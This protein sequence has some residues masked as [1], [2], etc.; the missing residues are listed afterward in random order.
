[1]PLREDRCY[2]IAEAGSNHIGWGLAGCR[3]LIY[4]AAKSGADAC[5][6]Q[7]FKLEDILRKV[8]DNGRPGECGDRRTELNPEW[9]P[10][11]AD[12]CK[13]HNID[14]LCTPFAAWAVE[15]LNPYVEMWKVGS[16]EHKRADI[17]D[18]INLTKKPSIASY[19]RCRP[20]ANTT[21]MCNGCLSRINAT[22]HLYC[23]S[24]YPCLDEQLYVLDHHY[25]RYDGLSDH[26]TSTIIPAFAVARGARIIE[27]HFRTDNTLAESPDNPHSLNPAK[28]AEMVA[29]IR[30]AELTCWR[31]PPAERILIDYPNRR[32]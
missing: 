4:Q 12:E 15:A 27:K 31:Q 14:F 28:F 6:F 7:L 30:L 17:W 2:V 9:I 1:V 32:E 19:G 5:K 29:N 8:D 23:E 18:A 16:F 21:A 22:Y 26:T 10:E 11:L 13:K 25:A 24:K 20:F 3:G